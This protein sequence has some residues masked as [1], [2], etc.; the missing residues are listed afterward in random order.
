MNR[1]RDNAPRQ[2]EAERSEAR[3]P[4]EVIRDGF[5]KASIWRNES[6]KGSYYATTFARTYRDE[7]GNYRDS[8][9]YVGTD[10]LK[11]SE[12]ARAAYGRTND[13]RREDRDEGR[14]REPEQDQFRARR[15][16]GKDRKG[17]AYDR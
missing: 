6:E 5:L 17:P 9:S 8:H 10:L 14:D 2:H 15:S 13:L 12:L 1:D 7:Q 16:N 11:L 4:A 3:E